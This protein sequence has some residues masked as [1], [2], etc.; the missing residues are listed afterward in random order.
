MPGWCGQDVGREL[1]TNV[2]ALALQQYASDEMG[3]WWGVH[4][5]GTVLRTL[6]GLLMWEVIFLDD[7]RLVPGAFLSSYQ[8]GPLDLLLH[9]PRVFYHR[10]KHAVDRRLQELQAMSAQAVG[11]AVYERW[12]EKQGTQCVGVSWGRV[13]VEVLQAV[14]MALGGHA[15]ARLFRPFLHHFRSFSGGLPDLL[16]LR[17]EEDVG[18]EMRVLSRRELADWMGLPEAL[19]DRLSRASNDL[20]DSEEEGQVEHTAGKRQNK[21]LVHEPGGRRR[22]RVQLASGEVGWHHLSTRML[23]GWVRWSVHGRS[24]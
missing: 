11:D 10:R 14:S 9:Q 3:G 6:F 16:L 18:E 5:E 2:E 19:L 12:E 17:L 8:S 24:R 1:Y 23:R 20:A 7:D 21:R 15:L 22:L 4:D 13:Q